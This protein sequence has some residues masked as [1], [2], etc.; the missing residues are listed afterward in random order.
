MK[1][2]K[3]LS[4]ELE[5]G[6]RPDRLLAGHQEGFARVYPHPARAPGAELALLARVNLNGAR[7]WGWLHNVG[8]TRAAVQASLDRYGD[9]GHDPGVLHDVERR[10]YPPGGEVVAIRAFAQVKHAVDRFDADPAL[11]STDVAEL[12]IEL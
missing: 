8:A 10:T 5:A 9:T 1:R 2:A 12:L 4:G 7:S 6:I 11:A 3:R